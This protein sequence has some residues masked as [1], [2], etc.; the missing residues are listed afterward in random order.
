M[1]VRALRTMLSAD[2][3]I[4]TELDHVVCRLMKLAMCTWLVSTNTPATNPVSVVY[5]LPYPLHLALHRTILLNVS[6]GISY[7]YLSSVF[8]SVTMLSTYIRLF[9]NESV[10]RS[11]GK[12]T[13]PPT[14]WMQ[15][16]LLDLLTLTEK[17]V[18]RR[19]RH[20]LENYTLKAIGFDDNTGRL[21][22]STLV[23][24]DVTCKTNTCGEHN[25][26]YSSYAKCWLFSSY[27][28]T[29]NVYFVS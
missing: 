23:Q 4:S 28:T 6:L 25:Y 12:Q 24:K 11:K 17:A 22:T 5:T 9:I 20:R 19:K 21:Y 2:E 13:P 16:K 1:K 26:P 29:R 14:K 10:H 7:P 27:D 18:A 3:D 15:C 8:T